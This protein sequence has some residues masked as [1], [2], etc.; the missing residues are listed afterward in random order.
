MLH[1]LTHRDD[2]LKPLKEL[3]GTSHADDE[4]YIYRYVPLS[5]LQSS[6]TERDKLY[7]KRLDKWNDPFEKK[8]LTANYCYNN[9]GRK[10]IFHHPFA[11]NVYG[12]C[13]TE[14]Y[15]CEAQWYYYG[16]EDPIV[17]IS[18]KL[19]KLLDALDKSEENF[20]IGR[21]DYCVQSEIQKKI[22]QCVLA[23]LETFQKDS[24]TNFTSVEC[25]ALLRPLFF[26]RL[27]FVYEREIRI[28]KVGN[29]AENDKDVENILLK[30]N[31]RNLIGKVTISPFV[32]EKF[33][34]VT[35]ESQKEQLLKEGFVKQQINISQLHADQKPSNINLENYR[36]KTI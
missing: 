6:N 15:N 21:V 30:E 22:A 5:S 23:D 25:K 20:Y 27:P 19:E 14:N 3:E 16:R 26:K 9:K 11:N 8:V 29:S 24:S 1:Y 12:I 33:D 32:P 10:H 31:F 2:L 13:F 36:I 17:L 18:V 35:P 34:N 28:L 4:K 7:M